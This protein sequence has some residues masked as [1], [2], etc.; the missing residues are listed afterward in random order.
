VAVPI[1]E[2]RVAAAEYVLGLLDAE[3]IPRLAEG[4]VDAD[5]I[6]PTV[7]DLYL[8]KQPNLRDHGW[9]LVKMLRELR[10]TLPGE[11]DAFRICLRHHLH[12]L[13]ERIIEP[14]EVARRFLRLYRHIEA[15]RE[16]VRKFESIIWGIGCYSYS[17]E[18]RWN[19]LAELTAARARGE[20]SLL[21]MDHLVR[22]LGQEWLQEHGPALVPS[23]LE[24]NGGN[25]GMLAEAIRAEQAFDRLPILA[26]AL[27]EAGCMDADILEHCRF[28]SQHKADC[29]VI[30]LL[31]DSCY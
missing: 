25:V 19:G 1:P 17:Y 28:P 2:L 14:E 6:T 30:E 15:R 22:K 4:L 31:L 23:W 5:M 24:A 8:T 18:D 21:S 9:K 3:E 11:Q 20:E 16:G 10:L 26:D 7:A 29:W 27:E 13:G 12:L